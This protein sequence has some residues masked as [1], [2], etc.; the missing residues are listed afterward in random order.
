M[1]AVSI[2]A[3]TIDEAIEKACSQF[4]TTRD[5]LK[6][7]IIAEGNP[8][9]LGFGSKK[10]LIR[11]GL[12]SID[13]ELDELMN[14]SPAPSVRLPS[15]PPSAEKQ[16]APP[17][18]VRPPDTPAPA[19][20]AAPAAS[21]GHKQELAQTAK[22]STLATPVTS[23]PL[24]PPA[25]PIITPSGNHAMPPPGRP[26]PPRETKSQ[27]IAK[28]QSAEKQPRRPEG[29]TNN[30]AKRQQSSKKPYPEASPSIA[31]EAEADSE[32]TPAASAVQPPEALRAKELLEG[33]LQRMN[34]PAEVRLLAADDSILLKI[35]GDGDGLLIGKKGQN[36]DAI[37]YIV[38]KAVHQSHNDSNR[39]VIDTEEY[40]NRREKSLLETA[41]QIAQKVK[42]THKPVTLG[43][44][45]PHDRRIIHL[46]LKNE[47]SL[48]TKSRGEGDFRKIVI[49]PSRRNS[50]EEN[51][52]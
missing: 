1:D 29:R 20:A 51:T 41:L 39:V 21:T 17:P 33:I 9:F 22:S 28:R 19:L 52:L 4:Q 32:T 50:P 27:N 35:Q 14:S 23:T 13:R 2:E 48:T 3:K 34:I 36:L 15:S 31:A 16:K 18:V 25:T 5:K 49:L 37:Q 8:G 26:A 44:M 45:N 40:R 7:E 6:I 12:L 38:N 47:K 30:D 10:A 24:T 43:P 42:K 11:A 46:A